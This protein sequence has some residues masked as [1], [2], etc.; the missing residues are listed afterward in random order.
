MALTGKQRRYLRG[1]G[2]GLEAVVHVGKDGVSDA[3]TAALGQ[4]LD[5]HELVKVKLGQNTPEDRHSAADELAARTH[6]ELVQVLGKAILLY[7]AH[8]DEPRIALPG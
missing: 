8:P 3:V 7:R 1:L 4:A 6:S 2:H 5:T